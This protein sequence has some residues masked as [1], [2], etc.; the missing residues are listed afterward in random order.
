VSLAFDLRP[1]PH[2]RTAEE[3]AAILVDPGFGVHFTDHMAVAT[4][5]ST[6]GWA[7]S[8]IVP[9]GPFT[10]DPATAVLHYAQEIFEG[11][12]A[13]RHAD[14]SVWLFRPD[15]N[16][17][18]LSRSARRMAL[19]ELAEEDFLASIDALISADEAWVPSGAS[20]TGASTQSSQ[21]TSEQ[22]LYLRP[23]MFASESF[24]GVRASRR[25]TYCCIA[26]PAGPYFASG[27]HPVRI[28]VSTTYNRSGPG[29]TGAAKTG[30]NY[31]SSLLAQAEAAE[32]GFDQ[33]M[34][35]DAVEQRWVEELGGMNVYLVTTDHELVTPAL[36][37]TILEGVTRDSIL[38]L[39]REFGL[40]PVE[41]QISL[42]ELLEGIDSGFVSEVFACGTAAVI[43]PIGLLADAEG[44]HKVGA[45]DT[46]E[47]TGAL[48]KKLL[49][50]QYGRAADPHGWMRRVL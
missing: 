36:S 6:D 17:A 27:V 7:D 19:P 8:A 24:L 37:G 18:R 35:T 40:T 25:V 23:F 4:W 44:D 31:A 16:A 26:S 43:T 42:T 14:G 28:W 30:G 3:R 29:G 13:Y 47:V 50:L 45:G 46:G 9:Y 12:K 48:R 39:S 11:L 41:R 21:Q 34:F 33:V 32:K 1:H 38:T 10:L 49:D 15:Q 5:T 22:S 20:D 2:P